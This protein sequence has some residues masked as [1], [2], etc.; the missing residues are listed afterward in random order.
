[1][2]AG[3]EFKCAECNEIH[4]GVPTF[5]A[6]RPLSYF[7]VPEHERRR[8]L[9]LGSDDCI[10]DATYFFVRGCV[11]IPIHGSREPFVWGV[12][13]SLSRESHAEWCRWFNESKRSH[14]GP[15]TGW[16]DTWLKV[17]PNTM[18]LQ[19]RIHLRDDGIRPYVELEPTTH[20]LAVE[21]RQGISVKRLGEIYA[22][23]THH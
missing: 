21:Q 3:F 4:R 20:P 23:M 9:L 11:E 13:V 22:R 18:N 12:W 5:G 10:I 2:S 15:F 7:A 6:D 14:V 17:Y 19:T 8:R 16:L 1:M